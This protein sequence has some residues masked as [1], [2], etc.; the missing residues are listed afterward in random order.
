MS[1]LTVVLT[2]LAAP[3]VDAHIRYLLALDPRADVVLCHG[4][5]REDFELVQW[6]DKLFLEEPSLR[7]APFSFQSYNELLLCI[8][9]QYMEDG[10]WSAAMLLEYDQIPLRTDYL[11]RSLDAFER[12]GADFLGID[13]GPRNDT[14][15]L[16]YIRFRDDPGLLTF[17]A[18]RSTRDDPRLL[19]GCLGTGFLIGREALAAFASVE[20]YSPCYVELYLPTIVYHLGFR[21]A[22]LS[23]LTDFGHAVRHAPVYNLQEAR[24]LQATG[25]TFVH[26][27]KDWL[28][29][30]HL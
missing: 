16:H 26:P 28:S 4:G 15:W 6:P 1:L 13:C 18:E 7:G 2:H 25:A 21:V 17:L 23:A 5:R 12:G 11:D 10:D 24:K 30:G 19:F 8:Y 29:L 14:N 20:H 27:F 3:A 22:D 9:R